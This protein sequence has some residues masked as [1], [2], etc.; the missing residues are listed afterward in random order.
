MPAL[1]SQICLTPLLTGIACVLGSDKLSNA[2]FAVLTSMQTIWPCLAVLA[3]YAGTSRMLCNPRTEEM[4]DT[5]RVLAGVDNLLCH[6]PSRQLLQ[7][8]A[9]VCE[10]PHQRGT[11]PGSS[12]ASDGL[13]LHVLPP[14]AGTH[15]QACALPQ[16]TS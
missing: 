14:A 16:N 15:H 9:A 1:H 7:P 11:H 6:L 10:R 8:G 2:S 12:S 13:L 3:V 5:M 4:V